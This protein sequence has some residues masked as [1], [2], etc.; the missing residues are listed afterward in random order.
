LFLFSKE[1]EAIEADPEEDIDGVPLDEE[2]V[3][4][5][6][7][8]EE[9]SLNKQELPEPMGVSD[10]NSSSAVAKFKPSKWEAVDPDVVESQAMT[11]SKWHQIE[12]QSTQKELKSKNGE[13]DDDVDGIPLVS[14]NLHSSHDESRTKKTEKRSLLRE[15]EVLV[16]KFQDDLESGR[17]SRRFPN[18]TLEEEVEEFRKELIR[19]MDRLRSRSPSLS[20]SSSSDKRTERTS[21]TLSREET[22]QDSSSSY[23]KRK[24]SG[25]RSPSRTSSSSTR[26]SR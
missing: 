5:L 23:R 16:L 25:S 2:D 14:S 6:P 22:K 18:L 24:R 10:N 21:Q 12:L 4:G 26:R 9:M 1:K 17:R 8:V 15:V 13:D 3:D 7:L 11:T 20:S 19:K